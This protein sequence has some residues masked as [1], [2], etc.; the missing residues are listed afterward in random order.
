MSFVHPLTPSAL[1]LGSPLSA[2]RLQGARGLARGLGRPEHL[3]FLRQH[4]LTP[5]LYHTLT[6]FKRQEVGAVPRLDDLRQDYAE[7]LR[8]YA[9]QERET[10]R[11]VETLAAA[12][13]EVILLKGADIRHR[14]Y[15]DPASRP[16]NDLDVLIAPGALATAHAALEARGYALKPW[17]LD[18]QPGF[19]ARF[20]YDVSYSTP[21]AGVSWV[22][23]HWEI[24]EVGAFYRLPYG[25]LRARS[26]RESRGLPA[27]VLAPEH[28][29]LHLCLHTYEELE[30]SGILKIVDLDRALTRFPLD[31]DLFLREASACRSLGPV[32]WIL[33]KM[34][35]LC[36][37]AVPPEVL[38]NLG[39]YRPN[40]PERVILSRGRA[41]LLVA[42][43]AALWRYLP[44][45][46]WPP[47]LKG[48]I[49]PAAA[50][51]KANARE[52]GN[53]AGYLR[54]LL[55]RTR[56]RT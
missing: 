27:L 13:V 25:L 1:A 30:F 39:A 33:Q 41:G 12:G 47:F 36:P 11:L 2:A 56:D 38:E 15:N 48:K 7:A 49:W 10:A 26:L 9:A 17:D 37:G 3:D 28:V 45:R 20:D 44:V 43:V 8:V 40:W 34:A 19:N 53:R 32:F 18:P 5:L 42:S 22:D 31:W 24:R 50:Y 35:R 14:L 16:M 55:G 21:A 6:G 23:V 54:H 4:K 52:F 29:L 46:A 51:L